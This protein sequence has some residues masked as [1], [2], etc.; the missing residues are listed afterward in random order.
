MKQLVE[1]EVGET[2]KNRKGSYK[3]LD[4]MGDDMRIRWDAGEEVATTV[5][6]QR[7]IRDNIQFELE[8]PSHANVPSPR[9]KDTSTSVRAR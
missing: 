6:M 1:F 3:V 5:T 8:H 7:Q 4:I 9:I 2:Y